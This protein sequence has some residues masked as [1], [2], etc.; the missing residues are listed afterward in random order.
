MNIKK[1]ALAAVLVFSIAAW[2]S[3]EARG[4]ALGVGFT[5]AG[6]PAVSGKVYQFAKI[7]D[8][9]Y[10]ATSNG[11]MAAGGN[12]P[13]IVNENDVLLVDDGTTPARGARAA[14]RSEADHEQAGAMGG[15]HALSLRSHRRQLD[16]R[17]RSAD[18]R[19]RICAESDSRRCAAPGAVQ[20]VGGKHGDPGGCAEKADR[21]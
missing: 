21:R 3:T 7:A 4:Q 1:W 14:R 2:F 15:Q 19:A 20:D 16:L 8:G 5:Q 11:P 10:Y 6:T 13:I 17:A 12:H 18:H 9:V